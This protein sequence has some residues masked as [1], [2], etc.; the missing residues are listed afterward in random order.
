[1]RYRTPF[2]RAKIQELRPGIF[3]LAK[4]NPACKKSALQLENQG[5]ALS[6]IFWLF[7]SKSNWVRSDRFQFFGFHCNF[8]LKSGLNNT[9]K[10]GVKIFVP[11]M[12]NFPWT[13]NLKGG[14]GKKSYQCHLSMQPLFHILPLVICSNFLP[15][16]SKQETSNRIF[17]K[18][19]RKNFF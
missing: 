7:M 3:M 1:M 17:S 14:M 16:L 2:F 5:L 8:W 11:A 13:Y 4:N 10:V 19:A 12:Y 9:K 15:S 6:G 18:G